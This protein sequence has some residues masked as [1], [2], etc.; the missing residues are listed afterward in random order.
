MYINSR[1]L[2]NPLGNDYFTS[3][4]TDGQGQGQA[5]VNTELEFKVTLEF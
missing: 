3:M 2:H 5:A 1:D 4:K